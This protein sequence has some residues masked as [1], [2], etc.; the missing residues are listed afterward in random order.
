MLTTEKTL[1]VLIVDDNRDGADA[2]GLLVEALGNQAHVTYGGTQ[3]LDVATAFRPDLMFVD[4]LMPGMNGCDL[5]TRIRQMPDFTNTK[6]VAITGLDDEGHKTL[7]LSSGFDAFLV[8]PVA[9]AEIKT[10]L[11]SIVPAVALA[12][13]SQQP[14]RARVSR[15]AE[16][17]LPMEEARR[18]RSERP[19][20]TLT[21]AES[22]AVI[23]DGIIRFQEE[24]LGWGSEQIQAHFIKD[25]LLVRI[26]GVLTHAERQL[27]KSLSPERGRDLI[28]QT[29]NQLLE[30]ARPMLESLVHEAAAVKVLSMHH[31]IST[32][33]GEEIVVFPL[34]EAP[35]FQIMV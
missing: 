24:Y 11:A 5:V 14:A 8:K 30:L 32:V 31:D 1:R 25:L 6:I 10:V 2:L 17:R 21:Q 4:L 23:C 35:R 3:A 20:H 22:E 9:L 27:A 33:T 19:S 29:R 34:A 15:G 26:L 18:I 13:Q 7:A 16:R 12:G 28:K